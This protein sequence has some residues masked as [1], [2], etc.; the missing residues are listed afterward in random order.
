MKITKAM[1]MVLLGLALAGGAAGTIYAQEGPPPRAWEPGPPPD[2]WSH[3]AHSG[4]RDGVDAARHDI[5]A[6][7]RPDP[8]RHDKYRHPDLPRDQRDDFRMGFLR[9]YRMV[10]EHQVHDHDHDDRPY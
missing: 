9:G 6:R 8:D 1:M 4:F 7:R 10:Y 2:S 5:D 3:A